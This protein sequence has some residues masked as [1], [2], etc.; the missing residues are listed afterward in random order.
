MD[1]HPSMRLT[2]QRQVILEAV[3][4]NYEHPTADEI[5]EQVRQRLPRISLATVYRNLEILAEI[6]LIR[7]LD[8]GRTQM[9]F[10]P[11]TQAHYHLTCMRCGRVEDVAGEFSESPMKNIEKTL[12]R[13]TKYGIFGHN[14]EFFGLCSQCLAEGYALSD[15][16]VVPPADRREG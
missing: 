13:L 2:K 9:R 10:D 4:S 3:R 15:E 16:M 7:K 11:N 12:G 14:L 6:G 5:Y 1:A 8:P